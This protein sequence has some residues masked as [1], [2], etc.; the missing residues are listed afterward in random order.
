MTAEGH[1]VA[2]LTGEYDGAARDV[3]IDAFRKGE[4]KVLIATNVLSRGID[5]SS[6]S[7]VINYDI[8]DMPAE[9]GSRRNVADPQTYLHRIGRTGR[10][11]RVGVSITFISNRTEW[12]ML[13]D[14][15]NYFKIEM[16]QVSTNDWDELEETVS[17]LIKSSRSGS[18]F[19]S[20]T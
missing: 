16:T 14:I 18:N 13:M 15:Q 10:F 12:T 4:A 1:H 17:K 5:V 6:V 20:R 8:P 7:L 19:N 9:P 2:A 3:I 11:G